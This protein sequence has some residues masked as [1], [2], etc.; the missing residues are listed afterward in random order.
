MTTPQLPAAQQRIIDAVAEFETAMQAA[1]AELEQEWAQVKRQA[2]GAAEQASK[3]T[4]SEQ[5][6]EL[7]AV[8]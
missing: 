6:D 7:E 3:Q 2:L 8:L 4:E 5:L 1:Q